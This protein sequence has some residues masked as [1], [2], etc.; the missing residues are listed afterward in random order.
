MAEANA[1]RGL[2]LFSSRRRASAEL[3]D[4]D[5][6][7]V[8]RWNASGHSTS[9]MHVEPVPSS[10]GSLLVI[11]RDR[12]L[13]QFSWNSELEWSTG[14]RAHHDL[15]IGDDGRIFVLVRA[16]STLWHEGRSLPVLADAI[17]VLSSGGEEIRRME[18]LPRMRQ[19]VPRQRLDRIARRVAHGPTDALVRPGGLGDVL[20]AN[21][22]EFTQRNIPGV[23]PKGSLLLSFRATS[24]IVILDPETAI[25]RWRSNVD[26]DGQHDATQLSNGHVMAFDNGIRRG[27]SRVVEIDVVSGE[28]VWSFQQAGFFSR[29][30]GG[31]QALPNGNVLIT[32]SD[33]GHALEVTRGGETVWEYWNPDVRRVGPDT[34]RGAI[35]RLNRFAADGFPGIGAVQPLATEHRHP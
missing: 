15:A 10:P 34:Q 35:Y 20:H 25:V 17:A 2:N 26:L 14:L 12:R 6:A 24:R 33:K 29:L 7:I 1:Q 16:R 27:W 31:A 4:M 23:A 13:A 32:E 19:D 18:L 11:E 21:S 8:H 28:I 9:W 30:R 5:G 3:V 22:I